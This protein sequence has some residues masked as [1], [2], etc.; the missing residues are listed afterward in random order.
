MILKNHQS[1]LFVWP[2]VLWLDKITVNDAGIKLDKMNWICSI[3]S[4]FLKWKT[5]S[6]WNCEFHLC[7][8]FFSGIQL[9]SMNYRIVWWLRTTKCVLKF[10]DVYSIKRINKSVTKTISMYII[11]C[12]ISICRTFSIHWIHTENIHTN[13]HY[14]NVCGVVQ[15]LSSVCNCARNNSVN[16]N[17]INLPTLLSTFRNNRNGGMRP[18]SIGRITRIWRQ[19]ATRNGISAGT[20]RVCWA[21][22]K[23]SSNK[24]IS[25]DCTIEQFCISNRYT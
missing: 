9:F 7:W 5:C 4:T 18:T 22:V 8:V 16:D 15:K 1:K 21:I 20:S 23:G 17:I 25:F 19:L 12:H 11:S 2:I 6:S 3:N 13:L 10:N 24:K 14:K